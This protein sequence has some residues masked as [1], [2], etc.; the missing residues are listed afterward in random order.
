MEASDQGTSNPAPDGHSPLGTLPANPPA[1]IQSQSENGV[2]TSKSRTSH[3][4]VCQSDSSPALNPVLKGQDGSQ[5]HQPR[6][7]TV[8]TL[9][10]LYGLNQGAVYS[11]IKTE[12]DFPYVNVG[13]KKKFLVDVAH[14][15][16][17]L[18]DRTKKQKH[19]HFSVPTALDLSTVFK[20][21]P[22]GGNK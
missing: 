21:K 17:W 14:F 2:S 9:A 16:T 11:F 1:D 20:N 22:Q 4:E 3:D 13:V 8:K 6:L 15:E 5:R 12:P 19:E 10:T 7:V 18:A